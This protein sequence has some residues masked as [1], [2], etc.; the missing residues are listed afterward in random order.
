MWRQSVEAHAEL[1]KHGIRFMMESLGPW[2]ETQRGKMHGGF[3]S[4][5]M[6][7]LYTL[8]YGQ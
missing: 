3:N 2:G 6:F 7:V 8:N 4:T 1:Q 5:N